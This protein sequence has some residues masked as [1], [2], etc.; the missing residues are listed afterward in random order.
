VAKA[1]EEVISDIGATSI[2]DMGKVM[3]SL[4]ETYTGQMD[5]GKAGAK[6]KSLLG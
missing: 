3:A 6:I 5:F 2:R 1:I 4:K